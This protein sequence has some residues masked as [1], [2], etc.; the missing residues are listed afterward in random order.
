MNRVLLAAL[1]ATPIPA[2]AQMDHSMHGGEAAPVADPHAHHMGAGV[3]DG[4]SPSTKPPPPPDDWAADSV[5]APSEMAAARRAML[6]EH[7]GMQFS[8][9]LV[10]IAEIAFREG[11]EGYRWDGEG[12][13]GGDIDRVVMKS[14]GEGGFGSKL[15]EG[16]LSLLWS[17]AVDPY[18]NLQAGA[19]QDF[20]SGPSRRYAS[21]GVEGL[22]PYWID[23]DAALFL[24]DK[25]QL[26]GR[27]E[28]S[29]DQRITQRLI[30]QPRVDL[31]FSAQDSRDQRVGS[32]L[33][34]ASLALRLRYE[35]AR[36]FAPY[37]GI[38]H[39]RRLGAAARAARTDSEDPRSTRLTAGISFWF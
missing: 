22:M 34:N 21:V 2:T 28:A 36:E 13:F 31:D 15:D 1:L 6:A 27:I 8:Q 29:Y 12:W 24:S 35:I 18:F 17:H 10:S 3:D 16:E 37:V 5:Y 26:F 4:S 9:I 11:K 39:E 7:G 33:T 32:G 25:G 23:F 14:E 30:A 19:R 38:S 20:G